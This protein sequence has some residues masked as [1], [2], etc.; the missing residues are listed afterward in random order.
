MITIKAAYLKSRR[1]RMIGLLGRHK[2][3]PIYLKT[4]FGIHT[5]GL[6]FPIDVLILDRSNKIVKMV[7]NLLPNQVFLW[8]PI[9]D[10]VYE[11]PS[12]YISQ[13]HIKTGDLIAKI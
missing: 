13:H 9:Y 7:E 2:A 1:A 3:I 4:H 12:G 11:L 8:L 6:K 10:Q 5:F